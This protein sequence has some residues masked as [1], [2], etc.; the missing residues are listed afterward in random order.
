MSTEIKGGINIAMKVPSHQY[1]AV[2]AFY[3]D[4]VGLP[5]STRRHRR[6]ASFSAPI[7]CG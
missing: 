3:R 1:E 7:V 5:L 4:V 6:K 2:I